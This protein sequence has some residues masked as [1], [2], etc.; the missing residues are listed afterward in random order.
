MVR[1][2]EDIMHVSGEDGPAALEH[3]Q[4]LLGYG[5]TGHT[6]NQVSAPSN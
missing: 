5:L 1:F 3:L 4:V 6:S 2:L